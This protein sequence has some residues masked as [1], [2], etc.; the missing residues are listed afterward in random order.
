MR[1]LCI[2]DWLIRIA[3]QKLMYP[4]FHPA[5]KIKRKGWRP[6]RFAKVADIAGCR[7]GSGAY[8]T[9]FIGMGVLTLWRHKTARRG[10]FAAKTVRLSASSLNIMPP[11]GCMVPRAHR[12]L[13]P[14]LCR[15]FG[16]SI[17]KGSEPLAQSKT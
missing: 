2:C 11:R 5:H 10:A 1:V 16:G 6:M 13:P 17:L 15:R 3:K 4:P 9:Q 12:S 7:Q 14:A 8:A